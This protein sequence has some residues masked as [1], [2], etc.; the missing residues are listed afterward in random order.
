MQP[1]VLCGVRICRGHTPRDRPN[2]RSSLPGR[3]HIA[4]KDTIQSTPHSRRWRRFG[5]HIGHRDTQT[6]TPPGF[7]S[8]LQRYHTVLRYTR[9]DTPKRV[10]FGLGGSRTFPL[11]TGEDRQPVLSCFLVQSQPGPADIDAGRPPI[12]PRHQKYCR[13]ALASTGASTSLRGRAA[14]MSYHICPLDTARLC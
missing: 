13:S 10:R 12:R 2:F 1:F 6:N 11:G 8:P 4:P 5:D 9:M 14:P 7:L 3:F